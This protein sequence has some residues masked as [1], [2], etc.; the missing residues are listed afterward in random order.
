MSEGRGENE[1]HLLD[2]LDVEDVP[3]NAKRF[4]ALLILPAPE[5]VGGDVG[6]VGCKFE[7]VSQASERRRRKE[8][9]TSKHRRRPLG[10][11]LPRS[12]EARSEIRLER[13][14]RRMG[15]HVVD[16]VRAEDVG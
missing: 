4:A 5:H 12:G 9:R 14:R 13:V 15:E 7:S 11:R 10:V 3:P 16:T 2:I 8:G 1:A 6:A